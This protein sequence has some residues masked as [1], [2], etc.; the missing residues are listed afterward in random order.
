MKLLVAVSVVAVLIAATVTVA[1][2]VAYPIEASW[3][4]NRWTLAEWTAALQDFKSVGGKIVWQRG[5]PLVRRTLDFFKTDPDWAWAMYDE[6]FYDVAV[7]DLNERGLVLG[8][9]Y[10]YANDE[11]YPEDIILRCPD[12]DRKI[13]TSRY[14]YR[15]FVPHGAW[16]G[17]WNCSYKKGDKLDLI[18]TIWNGVDPHALLIQ[19]AE[20]LD[21]DVY[22]P[23]PSVMPQPNPTA[24]YGQVFYEFTD[25]VMKSY[26]RLY[27]GYR[28]YKGV[29]QNNEGFLGG[30]GI[31]D[32][33]AGY[34]VLAKM[35]HDQGKIFVSSPYSMLPKNVVKTSVELMK[36]G[37]KLLARAGC[38]VIAVQDGRGCGFGAFWWNFQ[39][40]M[41]VESV[42]PGLAKIINYR[43][44]GVLSTFAGTFWSSNQLLWRAYEDAV[45]E[46]AAEGIKTE[47]WLNVEAFEYLRT[48]PCLPIDEGGNGMAE[49]LDRTTKDR[50][51][52]A[53]TVDGARGTHTISFAWDADF[54]CTDGGYARSLADDIRADWDRPIV[55]Y[56]D[57][58]AGIVRGYNLAEK[59]VIYSVACS[60]G[61]SGTDTAVSFDATWG[62]T[63]S[64]SY[65][66]QQVTLAANSLVSKCAKDSFVCIRATNTR[67]GKQAFHEYCHE[68]GVRP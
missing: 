42:D 3:M 51:D 19:A 6:F 21:M 49:L 8:D 62:K 61:T 32:Y 41:S 65:L 11:Y 29:Y 60:S 45:T 23:Q 5:V 27:S 37:F 20:K 39:A 57:A 44:P 7:K 26:Q 12:L 47:L 22:L 36:H 18:M 2:D 4:A 56:L 52:W 9:M 17:P 68:L 10:T 40:N 15:L 43:Y 1:A 48:A 28:S 59:S 13:V 63:H 55:S 67:T 64:R 46:L 53:L 50:L 38:D 58:A 66:L 24:E 33:A 35:T 30:W 25:R 34:T 54:L 16:Q 31:E 14:H